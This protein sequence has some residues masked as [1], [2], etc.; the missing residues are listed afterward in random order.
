MQ[1]DVY[2]LPELQEHVNKCGSSICFLISF[3]FGYSVFPPSKS[4]NVS[5]SLPSLVDMGCLDGCRWKP[6][7]IFVTSNLKEKNN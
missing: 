6:R 5:G 1:R 2:H 4:Q 7:N 3:S